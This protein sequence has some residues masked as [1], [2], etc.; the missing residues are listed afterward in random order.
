[1]TSHRT[2]Q[3]LVSIRNKVSVPRL[4]WKILIFYTIK[5]NICASYFETSRA[6]T[7]SESYQVIKIH[8]CVEA[9]NI[10]NWVMEVK[11]FGW[12]PGVILTLKNFLGKK[13][14]LRHFLRNTRGQRSVHGG[15]CRTCSCLITYLKK[16]SRLVFVT[17]ETRFIQN[18][19]ANKR[20]SALLKWLWFRPNLKDNVELFIHV[21]G[22][23][24][25]FPTFN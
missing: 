8:N 12:N 10:S 20:W 4:Y 18:W 17:G 6:T 21:T 16:K 14:T 19:V 25:Y 13:V 22:Y 15:L 9:T 24:G 5:K 11:I 23:I 1:M 7:K 3:Y 2:A